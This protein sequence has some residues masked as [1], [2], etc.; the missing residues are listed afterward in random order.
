[1]TGTDDPGWLRRRYVEEGADAGAIAGELGVD[2][3]TVHR[4]LRRHNI[5]AVGGAWGQLLSP[6]RLRRHLDAGLSL[7]AIAKDTGCD[8]ATVRYWLARHE[9]LEPPPASE[10]RR[11]RGWYER[12]G[13]TVGQVAERLGVNRTTATRRLLA[14]GI[15]LRPRG[16]PAPRPRPTTAVRR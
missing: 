1:M 2:V 7:T 6:E 5:P 10:V 3:S 8:R 11:L 12:D 13:L 14:A 15:T 9:L 4:A 16:R